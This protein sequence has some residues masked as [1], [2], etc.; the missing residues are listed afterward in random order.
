MTRR[1]FLTFAFAALAICAAAQ[2]RPQNAPQRDPYG[3]TMQDI[4]LQ[5]RMDELHHLPLEYKNEQPRTTPQGDP[6]PIS[7]ADLNVPAKARGEFEKGVKHLQKRE[8]QKSAERFAKAIADYP[9]FAAAHNDLGVAYMYLADDER[10]RAE[11]EAA[12]RINERAPIVYENLCR[13]ALARHEFPQAEA[14]IRK[15]VALLPHDPEALTLL[16]FAQLQNHE[17]SDAVTSG[18]TVHAGEHKNFA[19]IHVVIAY[20]M[21]SLGQL[22]Q[23]QLEYETFVKED[24]GNPRAPQAHARAA[25]LAKVTG[26]AKQ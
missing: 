1:T 11:F 24:P 12:S 19:V 3:R 21:E 7:A 22:Q 6:A 16:A 4:D 18:R 17:F 20:A 2:G 9:Q 5:Q 23:A 14:H 15:A 10:A 26:T 8:F 13:V 25:E